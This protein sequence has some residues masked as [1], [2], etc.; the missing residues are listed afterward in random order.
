M[1]LWSP[2]MGG[3]RL[4]PFL[5]LDEGVLLERRALLLSA[6]AEMVEQ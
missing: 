2:A 3:E 4:Y 5:T 1:D 6:S